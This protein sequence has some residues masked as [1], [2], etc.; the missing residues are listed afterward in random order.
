[1]DVI[2]GREVVYVLFIYQ[3]LLSNDLVHVVNPLQEVR[4]GSISC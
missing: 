2:G 1:M 4:D 3:H